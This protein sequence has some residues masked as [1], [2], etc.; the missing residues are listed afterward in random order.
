MIA[1]IA[2]DLAGLLATEHNE[3]R[4]SGTFGLNP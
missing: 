3:L 2:D 4:Y 1:Q